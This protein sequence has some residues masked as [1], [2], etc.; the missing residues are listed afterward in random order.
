MAW[1]AVNKDGTELIFMKRPVRYENKGEWVLSE[2][3]L[4]DAGDLPIGSIKKLID[5]SITWDDDPVELTIK[6]NNKIE[7]S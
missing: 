3:D 4:S 2:N 5:K 6:D 1:V 7:R